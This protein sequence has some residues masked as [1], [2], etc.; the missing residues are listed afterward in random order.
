MANTSVQQLTALLEAQN[1]DSLDAVASHNLPTTLRA[2]FPVI[3]AHAKKSVDAVATEMDKRRH[4][5]AVSQLL[6]AANSSATKLAHA[7]KLLHEAADILNSAAAP[8]AACKRNCS[9]CCHIPVALA[10]IEADVIGKSIGRKPR[11]L[12]R[13]LPTRETSGYAQPCPFL[14]EGACSIYAHRPLAC[15]L[16]ISLAPHD[17]LCR[18]LP[19]VSVPVPLLNTQTFQALYVIR[20]ERQPMGDIRDF[21]PP[22]QP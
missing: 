13:T 10:Q 22:E 5:T 4:R 18:L 16:H 8:H 7:V 9:H 6:T 12:A 14:K 1:P 21:F 2:Q 17:E 15:R 11:Q 3:Q 20:C 19:G